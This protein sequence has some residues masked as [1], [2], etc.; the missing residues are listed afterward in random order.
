MGNVNVQLIVVRT[1][2]VSHPMEF[3]CPHLYCKQPAT[4]CQAYPNTNLVRPQLSEVTPEN[5]N[6]YTPPGCRWMPN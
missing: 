2:I 6:K 5:L 1:R 4:T 3:I